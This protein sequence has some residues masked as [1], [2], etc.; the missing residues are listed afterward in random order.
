LTRCQ[1]GAASL[2]AAANLRR[3]ERLHRVAMGV[4]RQDL[5]AERGRRYIRGAGGFRVQAARQEFARPHAA[6]HSGSAAGESHFPDAI[7]VVS[8]C[9]E[10]AEMMRTRVSVIALALSSIIAA[11]KGRLAAETLAFTP[12]GTIPGPADL[13]RVDGGRAY[14]AAGRTLTIFDVSN[15]GA[16]ERAGSHTFPEKIWGFRV[17]G[18]L[19]YVAADFFGV[20][21]LDVSNVSSPVL[22]GSL[23]TPGQA[24][25]VAIY[26]TKALVA[27]HMSG[28]D[29]LDVSN[30]SNPVKLGSFFLDGY[31]R[32]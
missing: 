22:R 10:G 30:A 15:P 23:K 13:I 4:Q 7:K 17:V 19:V 5:S 26:G 31:A 2:R 20:G 24:K 14:V 18:S 29:Y 1:D 28:L 11:G 9:Q 27:D 3:V 25:S 12:V 16:P 6:R 32:D 21:V 8:D